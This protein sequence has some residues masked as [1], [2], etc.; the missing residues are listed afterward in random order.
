MLFIHLKLRRV[1]AELPKFHYS[2]IFPM[3]RAEEKSTKPK[4]AILKPTLYTIKLRNRLFLLFTS[5][6]L[7]VEAIKGHMHVIKKYN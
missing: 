2:V 6:R 5:F 1:N 4:K 3:L 7:K